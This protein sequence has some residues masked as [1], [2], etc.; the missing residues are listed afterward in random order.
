MSERPLWGA[1]APD[2][3][4]IC[5]QLPQGEAR[6]DVDRIVNMRKAEGGLM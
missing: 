1:Y 3:G 6:L 2:L 4:K 5:R